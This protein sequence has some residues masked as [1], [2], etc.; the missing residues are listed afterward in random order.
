MD[1]GGDCAFD[2]YFDNCGRFWNT[3]FSKISSFAGTY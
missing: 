1:A 3:I 2:D